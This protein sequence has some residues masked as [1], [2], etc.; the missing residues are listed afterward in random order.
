MEGASLDSVAEHVTPSTAWVTPSAAE[1]EAFNRAAQSG[2]ALP[3]RH[4]SE[5][6]IA[7]GRTYESSYAPTS[8]LPTVRDNR[9]TETAKVDERKV[10]VIQSETVKPKTK[11]KYWCCGE[12]VED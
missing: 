8:A 10:T 12:A 7:G 9:T 1:R 11:K 2:Q 4:R 3:S 6:S 5:K